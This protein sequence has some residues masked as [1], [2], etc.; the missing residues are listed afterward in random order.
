MAD[1]VTTLD[2]QAFMGADISADEVIIKATSLG[3]DKFCSMGG[4]KKI[5]FV[6]ATT[7]PSG[8]VGDFYGTLVFDKA[9]TIADGALPNFTGSTVYLPSTSTSFGEMTGWSNTVVYGYNSYSN[10]DSMVSAGESDYFNYNETHSISNSTISYTSEYYYTGSAIT[11]DITVTYP[12]TNK[13]L[14][15]T[16]GTD[17]SVAYSNNTS[18]GAATITV[19]G[20]DSYSGSTTK[21]FNIY[22]SLNNAAITLSQD[23]YN[24]DGTAKT[25]S[26]TVTAY[27]NT[28]TEGTDYT[29]SYSNNV[30]EGTATATITGT[31]YYS[32]TQTAY[33]TIS[34]ANISQAAIKLSETYYDYDGTEKKPSVTVTYNSQQLVE[35]TDYTLSYLNSTGPGTATVTITV[36]GIY[37]GECSANYTISAISLSN[38]TIT[39]SDTVFSYDGSEKVPTITVTNDGAILT[40]NINYTV[41]Y[42]NN[43]NIGTAYVRSQA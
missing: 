38:A 36:I 22:G 21:I 14:S 1:T 33:Y 35:G 17:Y 16:N 6:N 12:L 15:L 23:A 11:P 37:S 4:V 40:E 19:T 7:I 25:P 27:G 9:V 31:G 2:N 43:V 8:T 5:E 42:S 26:I 18:V 34:K 39:L 10:L 24:Y 30:E 41:S 28:L 32:G 20:I 29:V 3:T 13:T